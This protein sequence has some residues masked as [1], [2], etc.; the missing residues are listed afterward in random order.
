MVQPWIVVPCYNEAHR[1]DR[2][3][4]EA[5]LASNDCSTTLLFVDDGSTDGTAALL[6]AIAATN[7]ARASVVVMAENRGKAEA[8]RTGMR[9]ALEAGARCVG[10]WDA[11]LATPLHHVAEFA[12]LLDS[13]PG[14]DVV[15]GT[16]VRMLGRHIDRS[17]S[18]H[19]IGRVYATLASVALGLPVYDTQCGAKLFRRSAA[20]E[21]ALEQ[22]FRSRWS[23]DVEL[24]QRLQ[25]GWGDRG[26]DRILEVPL[27]AWRDVGRSNVSLSSGA[28]AFAVLCALLVRNNRSLPLGRSG[29][30]AEP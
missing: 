20:L 6:A 27:P 7:P 17:G 24:L 10:F 30:R 23:F 15:M 28:A 26:N 8:V 13:Q 16:R 12:A 21:R 18:R 1:L 22:P 14:I 4:F 2:A 5:K 9:A 29:E 3:A 25:H 19:L 11:D